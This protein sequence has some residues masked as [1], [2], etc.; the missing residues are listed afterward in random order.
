MPT[1]FTKWDIHSSRSAFS[2]LDTPEYWKKWSSS[3]RGHRRHVLENKAIGKIRIS[4][5]E[6]LSRFLELYTSTKIHDPNKAFV[7]RMT[8]KLFSGTE[9]QFRIF[10]AYVDDVPLA[11]ALFIDEG[12]TSE[13]WASFYHQDSRQYH[14]G[15]AIMDA[16]FLDSY[17]N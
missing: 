6:D 1:W 9:S 12:V 5:N 11:G 13:Y 17:G 4:E 2:I 8:N 7:K 16:W 10:I 15:I 14:L 3:A